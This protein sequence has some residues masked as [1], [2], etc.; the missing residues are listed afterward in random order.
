MHGTV[1]GTR[2]KEKNLEKDLSNSVEHWQR[3][4]VFHPTEQVTR[5]QRHHTSRETSRFWGTV[6]QIATPYPWHTVWSTLLWLPPLLSLG[7]AKAGRNHFNKYTVLQYRT[8]FVSSADAYPSPQ[9]ILFLLIQSLSHSGC[10]VPSVAA[11]FC[12]VVFSNIVH[13]SPWLLCSFYL[14]FLPSCWG[15]LN[16]KISDLC[17]VPHSLKHMLPGITAILSRVGNFR[18]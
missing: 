18:Q 2:M 8:S 5:Q 16:I 9:F 17:T 13:L 1:P 7:A 14:Y 3:P 11:F 6:N 4:I 12:F 15:F 10:V